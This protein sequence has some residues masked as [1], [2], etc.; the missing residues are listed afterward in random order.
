MSL[1][2]SRPLV[3]LITKGECDASNYAAAS[4][5]ILDITRV[6]VES[7]VDLIQVREK[8]LGGRLLF[9]LTQGV[10]AIVRGSGTKLLV[11]D[12]LD[13]A[14]ATGADGVHLTSRSITAEVVRSH[15]PPNFL[16]GVSC[17]SHEDLSAVAG[18]DLAL[19]G[20]VF[21]SPGKGGGVGLKALADVCND[22]KDLPIIAIGGIDTTNYHDILEAGAA[23]LAAIRALNDVDSLLRIMKELGR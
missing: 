12:R 19:F 18:A 4:Q 20:P 7:G 10:A 14:V 6:A 23:G 15:A 16:I 21:A 17:H 22:A 8:R 13:V 2:L 1:D 9:E 3:Y 5:Q 11:N